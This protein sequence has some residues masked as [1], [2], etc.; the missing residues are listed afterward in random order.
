MKIVHLCLGSFYPDNY[1]YQE[2]M[3][4]KFHKE[5]GF[6]VEVIAS[7][8]SFDEHGKTC[9]LNKIGSYQNEYDI[10]VTRL[11]YKSG[12]KIWK[13]FKRYIGTYDAI[14]KAAPD[15]IFIHG[16]QFL[17][18][19]QV[20]KYLKKHPDVKVFVD[21]HA[22]FSNSATNWLSKNI[23]H[24]IIWRNCAHKIEPYA[25]K[26]YGVLPARVDFL[27]NIYKL[28]AEKCELL[29]MGADDEL[30][31]RAKTNGTRKRIRD[32]Y[33]IKDNDFLIMTGGKIDPWKTQTILL[34]QAVHNIKNESVKL[35]VFG[36]VTQELMEQVK[37]LADGTKVQ[38]IGWI[39]S[40]DS[41]DY[42]EAADL[43]VFPGRHSVMWEQVVGQGKPMLV[44]D[45]AGT[46][47]VDIGGNVKFLTKDSVEEIQG[48]IEHLL[49][50]PDEYQKMKD[51]A[52]KEG[53]KVF[54]YKEIA[55]RAI[56][57]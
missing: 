11:A 24:K 32:E 15:I 39:Q 54:S 8:Q 45:W 30:V 29:V 25:T 21:N 6:D 23:L 33:G 35:I 50:N 53:M 16:C 46:H 38:Y 44:K 5:L 2:N 51:V 55:R 52:E 10:K 4:P 27:K 22:D 42:F 36:S 49:A 37:S 9:Y 31:E 13:K 17:D 28:P 26:F 12:N 1:S 40:K 3:L 57:A 41:Y 47:H 18:I 56:K 14:E 20:V 7:T 48:E 19:D 34:M 43:V